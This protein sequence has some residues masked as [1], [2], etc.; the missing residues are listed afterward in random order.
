MDRGSLRTVLDDKSTELTIRSR[1]SMALD[2]A[3][4]MNYLHNLNP[5]VI[6]RDLK[7][8]NLLVNEQLVVK[9]I[10][11]GSLCLGTTLCVLVLNFPIKVTDFGLA[12]FHEK[13]AV[14]TTFCGTLP[15]T[16]PEILT[17]I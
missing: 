9:V 12:K 3:K 2:A 14:S 13:K 4:G 11:T 8:Q 15:W 5:P 1:V 7:S 17:G 16:A 6:H 10:F